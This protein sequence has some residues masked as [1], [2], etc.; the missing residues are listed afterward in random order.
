MCQNSANCRAH[1]K[2]TL[3]SSLAGSCVLDEGSLIKAREQRDKTDRSHRISIRYYNGLWNEQ[4]GW[5]CR[6]QSADNTN[7]WPVKSVL[8]LLFAPPSMT[9]PVLCCPCSQCLSILLLVAASSVCLNLLGQSSPFLV[10]LSE[11]YFEQ[12]SLNSIYCLR[13]T[14]YLHSPPTTFKEIQ[15]FPTPAMSFRDGDDD[16]CILPQSSLLLLPGWLACP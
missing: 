6:G 15:F 9:T 8:P 3:N 7:L 1:T 13:F 11:L 16:S 10:G 4:L 2:Y 12:P 14:Y 5:A